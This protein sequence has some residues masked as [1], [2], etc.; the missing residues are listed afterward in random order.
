MTD[1][2]NIESGDSLNI[3]GFSF[4]S[5][6]NASAHVGL[7]LKKFAARSWMI[8][9]L[10]AGGVDKVTLVAV[11]CSVIRSVIEFAVPVYHHLLNLDQSTKLER[12]QKQVM[13]VIF[14]HETSYEEALEEAKLE[15]L[16][17]RREAIVEKPSL[18]L[19]FYEFI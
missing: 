17:A 16:A 14:G 6:P 3:L 15:T 11:Y 18:N 1:G 2:M 13:K 7:I 4:S 12:L 19:S 10:H 9:H 8:R 5:K